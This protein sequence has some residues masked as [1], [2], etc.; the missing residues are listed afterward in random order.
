MTPTQHKQLLDL[1]RE[2]IRNGFDTIASAIRR[3]PYENELDLCILNGFQKI[4]DQTHC[5]TCCN[6]TP[7]KETS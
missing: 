3:M 4:A 1:L 5:P 6:C 7:T 2:E